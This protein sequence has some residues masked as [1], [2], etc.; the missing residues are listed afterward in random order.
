MISFIH[1][2]SEK[3]VYRFPIGNNLADARKELA[4]YMGA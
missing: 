1:Y 2:E 3:R 4:T